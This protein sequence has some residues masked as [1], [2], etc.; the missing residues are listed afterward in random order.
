MLQLPS[1]KSIGGEFELRS[2]QVG[3]LD[4][5]SCLT[6][7]LQGTWVL[8]GRAAIGLILKELREREKVNHVHLPA[9][10]CESL[11]EPVKALGLTY[12]FYSV[13][14][15]LTC[16]PEP[17]ERSAVILIHYFGSLNSATRNMRK[18]AEEKKVFLI[19]D[20]S[21][22]LLTDFEEVDGKPQ[23]LVL[24]PRKFAPTLLG[25]WCNIVINAQKSSNEVDDI[26]FRLLSARLLRGV[27]LANDLDE[28]NQE[29][30]EMY[31]SNFNCIEDF[32]NARPL[33]SEIPLLSQKIIAGFDW[34]EVGRKRKENW[35]ELNSLLSPRVLRLVP[36]L[37]KSDVP[38]GLIIKVKNRDD[39][40]KMMA[41][42]RIFCP[43]H[44]PLPREIDRRKYPG[45]AELADV[46]LT[47]PIDQRYGKGEMETISELVNSFY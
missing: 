31:L 27:Y 44:W 39:L 23:Y 12:S 32:L 5:L 36:V 8:S 20:A 42:K 38:L 47:L 9:F 2:L 3:H 26:L 15:D 19:E 6:K 25:A 13:E 24:N 34:D 22:A 37:Q 7:K 16:F 46:C 35:Q 40:R 29:I 41:S 33:C 30:E 17:P 28:I 1:R 10:L 43:V 18:L 14:I 21:H 45:A 4:E 11:I